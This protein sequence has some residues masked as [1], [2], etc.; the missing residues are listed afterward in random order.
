MEYWKIIHL[1]YKY[2]ILCVC[3]CTWHWLFSDEL[4][5]QLLFDW[6][7]NISINYVYQY[8]VCQNVSCFF[9]YFFHG[10][11]A[12][13]FA[14]ATIPSGW[15]HIVLNYIGSG[16][17]EG[18]RVFYNGIQVASDTTSYGKIRHC[19]NG[20]IVIGRVYTDHSSYYSSV[21]VDELAFLNR[22]LSNEEVSAL[23]KVG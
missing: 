14:S 12:N 2:K 15:T 18:I 20:R 22:S 9:R 19:P 10:H 4:R 13:Y 5:L 7:M 17:G 16:S 8:H 23:H 3:V 1:Y 6:W 21:E 11:A